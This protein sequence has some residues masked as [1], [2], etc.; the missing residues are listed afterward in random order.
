MIHSR[1]KPVRRAQSGNVGVDDLQGTKGEDSM[2]PFLLNLM[3][4]RRV[5]SYEKGS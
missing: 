2:R 5:S 1:V 3:V 4:R